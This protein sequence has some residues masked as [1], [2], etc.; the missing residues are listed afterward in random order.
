MRASLPVVLL[1]LLS[2]ALTAACGLKD[3]LY[4]PPE[5]TPAETSEDAEAHAEDSRA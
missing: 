3:D 5:A 2:T 1:L 4:L